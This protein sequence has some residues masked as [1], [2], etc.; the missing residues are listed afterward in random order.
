MDG[1]FDYTQNGE[2]WVERYH[3]YDYCGCGMEQSPINLTTTGTKYSEK[4][5]FETSGYTDYKVSNDSIV[6]AYQNVW[7]PVKEGEFTLTDGDGVK[8]VFTPVQFHFHAPAEH[9]IDGK[10]FDLE[11]HLVHTY[12][13]EGSEALLGGVIGFFFDRSAGDCDNPFIT[14][15]WDDDPEEVTIPLATFLKNTDLSAY[16]NYDGSL[17]TPPCVEGIKWTVV[18]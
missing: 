18:R 7:V 6:R 15:V 16:W 4:M 11:M 12:K 8:C 1:K 17:T 10:E 5:K 14:K 2:N 9:T 13:Q 3:L